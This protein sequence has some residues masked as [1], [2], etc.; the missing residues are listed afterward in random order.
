MKPSAQRRW[1]AWCAII[2]GLLL[3]LAGLA[4]CVM[5][6]VEAGFRRLGEADQSLLFWYLPILFMGLA[7]ITLGTALL[8]WGRRL[9][10][11]P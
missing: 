5:Y 2:G 1:P 7:G 8:W 3:A 6:V 11:G 9:L 4:F 10:Q